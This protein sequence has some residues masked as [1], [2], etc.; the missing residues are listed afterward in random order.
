[1][2]ISKGLGDKVQDYKILLIDT[3]T[4][5]V[6][7]TAIEGM[8]AHFTPDG[9]RLVYYGGYRNTDHWY[10]TPGGELRIVTLP[11]GKPE[12]ILHLSDEADV[13]DMAFS[14]DGAYLALS[15][16]RIDASTPETLTRFHLVDLAT[17]QDQAFPLPGEKE[18][19][20]RGARWLD[21]GSTVLLSFFEQELSDAEATSRVERVKLFRREGN[22]WKVTERQ[23]DLPTFEE[24]QGMKQFAGR[25]EQAFAA[26]HT[27]LAAQ[28]MHRLDEAQ[29]EYAVARDRLAAILRDLKAGKG[30][31]IE[32]AKLQPADLL[33]YDRFIAEQ[34]SLSPVELSVQVVHR[35]LKR[36]IPTMLYMYW[37]KYGQFPPREDRASAP[38]GESQTPPPPCFERWARQV[39]DDDLVSAGELR[40]DR[41][42]VRRGAA[43]AVH[44]DDR[45]V[46][47]TAREVTDRDALYHD[48]SLVQPGKSP[49]VGRH[50][51]RVFFSHALFGEAPSG[52]GTSRPFLR[53]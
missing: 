34:A 2:A 15:E 44:E 25:L 49:L 17:K 36:S 31:G 10:N 23:V 13:D 5:T 9:K 38:R 20:G 26:Y 51:G 7:S 18:C 43:E 8:H 40:C 4:G 24:S 1:V 11:D 29:R 6:Q 52:S 53:T 41:D 39:G 45:R 28:Y 50:G 46:A 47:C 22:Q 12:P 35:S 42:P 37:Q 32:A 33:P 27:A 48:A 14:P 30:E 21:G 19:M 16:K 3:L